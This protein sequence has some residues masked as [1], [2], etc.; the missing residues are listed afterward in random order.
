MLS[1]VNPVVDVNTDA[2]NIGWQVGGRLWVVDSDDS[3]QLVP[4]GSIGELAIEG[5]LLARGYLGD[6]EKTAAAFVENLHWMKD[7]AYHRKRRVYLT[8]DLVRCNIDGSILF[9]GRK[10][11]QVKV[12]G[13]RI[14]LGDVENN[15]A[16]DRLV[17]ATAAFAPSSGAC[18]KRLVGVLTLENEKVKKGNTTGDDIRVLG[19]S[20]M[21]IRQAITEVQ[22]NLAGLV[23]NYMVPSTWFVLDSFPLTAHGKID[24]NRVKKWIESMTVDTIGN[25]ECVPIE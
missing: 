5:P 22:M 24:R 17:N 20:S 19:P 14:E 8:G 7:F 23:Q 21:R 10:D 4:T 18:E 2:S 13:F 12:R 25:Y 6:R 9:V 15:I 3:N 11:T 1:A 16:K